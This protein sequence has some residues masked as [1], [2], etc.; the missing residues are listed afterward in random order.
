[1]V[2]GAVV[3]VCVVWC[4]GVLFL[5]V[6]LNS[7]LSLSRSLSLFLS[8]SFLLLSCL[9]LSLLSSS[10]FSS[11]FPSRQQ[12]LCKALINVCMCSGARQVHSIS[13]SGTKKK[14]GNFFITETFP[15][16]E[17]FCL[18]VFI[19]IRKNRRRVKLQTLQFY[20]NSKTIELQRVK[21]VIILGKMVH[22]YHQDWSCGTHLLL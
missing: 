6:S 20:V 2:R 15:V 9:P 1:M 5:F 3:V 11:L 19:L 22:T 8:C 18:T 10:S 7:L 12:T 21:T 13:F 4:V 17:L 16:R 14:V